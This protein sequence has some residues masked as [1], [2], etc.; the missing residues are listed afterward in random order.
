MNKMP[1]RNN[2]NMEDIMKMND[3]LKPFQERTRE[4]DSE[5]LNEKCVNI[6]VNIKNILISII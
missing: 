1:D 2:M 6:E 3:V 4:N 5:N